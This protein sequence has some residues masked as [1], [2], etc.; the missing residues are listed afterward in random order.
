MW[1]RIPKGSAR[2]PDLIWLFEQSAV[3]EYLES[4]QSMRLAGGT[5]RSEYLKAMRQCLSN[6]LFEHVLSPFKIGNVIWFRN[7][8]FAI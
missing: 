6:L 5:S 1:R 2:S 4:W 3:R 7:D 8:T